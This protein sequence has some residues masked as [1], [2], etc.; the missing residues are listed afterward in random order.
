MPFVPRHK[1]NSGRTGAE[2][3]NNQPFFR[4]EVVDR[5][6][7]VKAGSQQDLYYLVE[8]PERADFLRAEEA[9]LAL[10]AFLRAGASSMPRTNSLGSTCLAPYRLTPCSP[11][12]RPLSSETP[13]KDVVDRPSLPRPSTS[14]SRRSKR[15]AFTTPAE[16]GRATS[17]STTASGT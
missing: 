13:K 10:A 14:Y 12:R 4:Y 9:L 5:G 6:M 3:L 15:G 7:K 2:P 11:Q 8:C 17:A 1:I 16:T